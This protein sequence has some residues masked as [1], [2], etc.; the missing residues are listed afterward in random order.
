MR[1]DAPS[2]AEIRSVALAMRVRDYDEFCALAFADSREAL[3]EVLA[4]RYGERDDTFCAFTG[5]DPI[6]VGAMVQSRPN[7]VTLMFFATD[8]LPEIGLALTK[9]IT[10]RLFPAYRKKGVH[11]IE[12][13]SLAGYE[14][15]H[16]WIETLGLR[17]E[18]GPFQGFGK[19]GEAFVQFAWVADASTTGA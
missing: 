7:V 18:A 2:R 17:Q 16:R 8:R 5:D 11:R 19:N 4:H 13:V 14:E 9:F 3:A 1:I 12:C 10:Q 6:A 15:V